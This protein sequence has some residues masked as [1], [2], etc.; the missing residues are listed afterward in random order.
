VTSDTAPPRTVNGPATVWSRAGRDGLIAVVTLFYA[1]IL[2]S[3]WRPQFFSI[4]T[5]G[6]G[7][8][9]GWAFALHVFH[10]KGFQHGRDL[11]FPYGP[12]GFLEPRFYHPDTYIALLFRSAAFAVVLWFGMW[13]YG[14]AALPNVLVRGVWLTIVTTLASV[15]VRTIDHTPEFFLCALLLLIHFHRSRGTVVARTPTT[16]ARTL[17]GP[18]GEEA[19]WW[20]LIASL[21]LAGSI[22]FSYFMSGLATVLVISIDELTRKRVPKAFLGFAVLYVCCHVA[23]GQSL[24]SIV[25]YLVASSDLAAGY[26]AAMTFAGPFA[27]MVGFLTSAAALL[28]AAVPR[29]PASRRQQS[30]FAMGLIAVVWIL[31]KQGYVRHEPPHAISAIGEL[32]MIVVL[33]LPLALQRRRKADALM[34]W[35]IAFV[36]AALL[37]WVVSSALSGVGLL[38]QV[39]LT[40]QTLQRN[41]AASVRLIQQGTEP[42][43]RQ[44]QMSIGNLVQQFPLPSSIGAVDVYPWD[45]WLPLIHDVPYRPRPVFQ[46]YA[47]FTPKLSEMNAH[48]LMSASTPTLLFQVKTIDVR[49]PTVDDA[50]SWPFI[51]NNYAIRS[52]DGPQVTLARL[53]DVRP[54]ATRQLQ[55]LVVT[56]GKPFVLP[57]HDGL[58]TLAVRVRPSLLGRL[59]T[60]AYRGPTIALELW[61]RTGERH[62]FRYLQSLSGVPF[63]VS[64]LITDTASFVASSRGSVEPRHVV[65]RVALRILS[66]DVWQID[67]HVAVTVGA[68][69][70]RPRQWTDR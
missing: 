27:G 42:L 9:S 17:S 61:T 56:M 25:P 66:S 12:L 57:N 31:F 14:R 2:L 32:L 10:A 8:D 40:M 45:V 46:S 33:Y 49:L 37:T 69:E 43:Q 50:L 11:V 13:S 16:V 70:L 54:P 60:I 67:P 1:V 4:E 22:K 26:S 6:D 30:F 41:V 28:F 44:Y 63:I 3:A 15:T 29:L 55:Q 48:H 18:R 19:A 52:I 64:P 5:V 23:A 58:T 68:V 24:A 62:R 35:S 38:G 34:L 39:S 59:W 53:P 36:P 7:L 51:L 20:L 21:A 47:A 65:D